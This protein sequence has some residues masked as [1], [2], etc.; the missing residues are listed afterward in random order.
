MAAIG[1]VA[2]Q[3]PLLG[4]NRSIVKYGLDE[5]S[6]TK[7]PGL[8]ALF[9]E[10]RIDKEKVGTYEIGF[11]IAPRINS[12]GRLKHG[13][14]SLRL[15]CTT[16]K[17]KAL[18]IAKNIGS[19][20]TE[21]QRIVDEVVISVRERMNKYGADRVIVIADEHYH[22]GVIGLAAA[23]LVEEFYRPAIVLSKKGDI[24]K[25]SARS[26]SGFNIIEVIR[27]L[28]HLYIEGGGHPMAA[29]FSIETAN[30]EKFAKELN[31]LAKPLL[32][33]EVLSRRLKIDVEI[34]F[35]ELDFSLLEKI[36]EFEPTGLG[37]PTPTFMTP[38]VDVIDAKLVGRESK[39]LKLRLRK[40][41]HIFDS[42]Y[43][44][45]GEIYSSLTPDSKIDVVYQLEEDSWNG[46]KSLQ[47]KIR[48]VHLLD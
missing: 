30:I 32:T 15:L 31:K 44:G 46:N 19:T 42:I 12:M 9:E 1:T 5:L 14:E 3:L 4:P 43:F 41:E 45:G 8:L 27:Q 22:E 29:G 26:V 20:N 38:Q 24:A 40:D 28:E 48:D 34:N 39:H 17:L 18:E 6:S 16:N 47:L 36:L 25:A 33:D 11:V 21:R 23:K 35:D 13:L 7:R 10:A 37:N 2:D